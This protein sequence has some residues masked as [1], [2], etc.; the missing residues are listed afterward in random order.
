MGGKMI[1]S[2]EKTFIKRLKKK[3]EDALEFVVD[4]Y[5]ELVKGCVQ[6]VLAPLEKEGAIEESKK[7]V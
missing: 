4:Q 1:K 7:P 6:K 2:N 3:K 5:L